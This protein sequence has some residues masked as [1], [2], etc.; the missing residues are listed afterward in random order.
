MTREYLPK[1]GDSS[2]HVGNKKG[3]N[4]YSIGKRKDFFAD[5]YVFMYMMLFERKQLLHYVPFFSK[6]FLV[7]VNTYE[8]ATTI[9]SFAYVYIDL[10]NLESLSAYESEYL[11]FRF[12]TLSLAPISYVSSWKL[13][14][15]HISE[16]TR[17]Y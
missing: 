4:I 16:P 13:S 6:H 17:P 3:C 5:S 12:V 8:S 14:L 2:V 11:R 1:C 15:I 7:Y 9:F 10:D